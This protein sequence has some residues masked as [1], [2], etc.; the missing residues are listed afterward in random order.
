[1]VNL[2]LILAGVYGLSGTFLKVISEY[3]FHKKHLIE[4]SNSFGPSTLIVFSSFVHFFIDGVAFPLIGEGF[5]LGIISGIIHPPTFPW[6]DIGAVS[7]TIFAL[8]LVG[9]GFIVFRDERGDIKI[10]FP[11]SVFWFLYLLVIL[12]FILSSTTAYKYP[13]VL[14]AFTPTSLTFMFPLYFVVFFLMFL[15]RR[16][17]ITILKIKVVPRT[18]LE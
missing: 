7:I 18:E 8:C 5:F 4:L 14:E 13:Y 9:L 3:L 17:D 2:Y 11:K 10:A 6:G 1:M 15:W 16:N 12:T